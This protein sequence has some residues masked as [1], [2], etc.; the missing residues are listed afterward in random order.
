[1]HF[2]LIEKNKKYCLIPCKLYDII[3]NNRFIPYNIINLRAVQPEGVTVLKRSKS[4]IFLIIISFIALAAACGGAVT[5]FLAMER[6]Y[7]PAIH[8]FT[9]DSVLSP[10]AAAI[11]ASGLIFAIVGAFVTS[12]R[13]IFAEKG[14][15]NTF[16]GIFT[17]VLAG[18]MCGLVFCVGVKGGIG[19][20]EKP[21][22]LLA[23]LTF[24]VL[25]AV[26]FFLKAFG[27]FSKKPALSLF[28]LLPALMC[29]FMILRLYFNS[30][31]PLNSPL[32]IFEIVML[33]SFMFYFTAETGI[34]ILRPKMNRKYVFA[35]I[36]AITSGGMVA[37]SRL[38]ARIAD[39]TNYKFDVVR[40]AFYAVIWICITVSFFERLFCARENKESDAFFDNENEDG[41]EQTSDTENED[42]VKA[43]ENAEEIPEAA[44][45]E[46]GE[47]TE[48]D[49]DKAS[50]TVEDTAEK[51]EEDAVEVIEEDTV[52][53]IEEAVEIVEDAAETAPDGIEENK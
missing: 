6:D 22:I 16:V 13:L 30:E 34:S 23:E 4:K 28:G 46:S 24:I 38:A 53:V 29:A 51:V 18:L 25:S 44:E 8:H 20:E 27:A 39:V 7:E 43:E 45:D 14:S 52:E 10:T 1:M 50:E 49:A 17:A 12:K 35:G 2:A 36:L 19:D 31:E 3:Q 26:Y 47:N 5:L 15:K 21:G 9:Y 40:C 48:D 41:E 33:V 32:K 37:A 11:C 42:D